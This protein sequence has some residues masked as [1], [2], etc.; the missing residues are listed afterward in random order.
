MERLNKA[1]G[2]AAADAGVRERLARIGVS[3]MARSEAD[4]EKFLREES[5]RWRKVIQDNGI[6]V[7]N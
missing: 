5:E 1:F 4:L 6:K 2:R 7:E 3:V